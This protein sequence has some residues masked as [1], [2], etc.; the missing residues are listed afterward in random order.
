MRHLI[1]ACV[2]LGAVLVLLLSQA[3]ANTSFFAK[4]LTW[5]LVAG[6]FSAIIMLGLISF[7]LW[8]LR[9]KLR[10]HIFGSKLTVRLL[11]IFALMALVPGALV[12]ALSVQFI[13]KSIDSWF[14]VR[15]DNALS[16]GLALGRN[17]LDH[18]LD[19]LGA[20]AEFVAD[21]M[22]D[23][24]PGNEF[25]LLNE[26]REQ[27][28]VEEATLLDSRGVVVAF[29]GRERA[30]LAPDVPRATIVR[31]VRQRQPYK[32]VESTSEH[33]RFLLRVLVPVNM[34]SLDNGS[35][36]LQLV[37]MAPTGLSRDAATVQSVARDY[38]ELSF[39]RQ[40]LTRLFWMTLT[41]ALLLTLLVAV[42]LSFYLSD[43]LSAPLNMLAQ[44]ARAVGKGDF[45][46]LNPVK[47][48]DELGVLTQSFNTMTRRLG[49]AS[50]AVA[51]NQQQLENAKSYLENIL[52]HLSAGV[53][54]FDERFMLRTA[55]PSGA[56]ILS[57]QF[58]SVRGVKLQEWGAHISELKPFAAEIVGEFASAG[59]RT[60]EKQMEFFG[61]QG[62]RTLLVRGTRLPASI[63]S[64]YIVVFDDITHLIQAQ[65]DAAW[66]E[67]AR[68]LAHE[69]K[70][71][72]TPI[73]LSAERMRQ[74]LEGKL[75]TAEAQLLARSTDTIVNQVAALKSM[76]DDF[77]EYAKA[78][79][80]SPQSLDLNGLV[81][82]VLVL[83]ES[84]G[85]RISTELAAGLPRINGD[86]K[87]LRQVLHNLVQN[88]LDALT[89]ADSP[90]ILVRTGLDAA[91]VRLSISDNGSG[92]SEA[93]LSRVF[94]P[95]VTTKPRGTGLG[96]A[97][98]KRIVDEHHG[99]IQVANVEPH[100][101]NVSIVLPLA[102]AA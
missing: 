10:A 15:I 35:R 69:I 88:A 89:D 20:K 23:A 98:V 43:R 2:A 71:P 39:A 21:A 22:S 90:L 32:A 4:N 17:A 64:G 101:A 63:D 74:K 81:R 79:R 1:L 7:Q 57:V 60:W 33:G 96:L 6:A 50:E 70:N 16:S 73:Q 18:L 51:R 58:S 42:L 84:M 80:M 41:L 86:V 56:E 26:L 55:N 53:L 100:G 92:F 40:D 62:E 68:R 8:Q 97:I 29:S 5:L 82:E 102:E 52:A 30:R 61:K 47:S 12:Y 76:V 54:A 31:Q 85:V 24:T 3:T 49:E 38:S 25:Q 65:R 19:E 27:T 14:D 11:V 45:S 87:L 66:G 72:L 78:S 28:G 37:E 36:V 59:P 91:G 75:A 48:R 13:T 94:E 83:Y 9:R 77:G 67:V 34:M 95:Y 93:L 44:S 99:R 46:K